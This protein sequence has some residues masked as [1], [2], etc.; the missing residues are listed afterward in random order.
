MTSSSVRYGPMSGTQPCRLTPGSE[1][2]GERDQHR[3]REAP[4]GVEGVVHRRGLKPA[5]DHAILALLVA[6]LAPIILPGRRLHQLREGFRVAVLQEI[7]RPLP[8]EHV[9]GRVPPGRALVV[10]LAHEEA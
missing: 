3:L 8:P 6:A 7:A 4:R 10:L 5:V 2:S 9:V 1:L